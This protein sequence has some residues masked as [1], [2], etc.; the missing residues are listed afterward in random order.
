MM[1]NK[2]NI[3]AIAGVIG[4][5]LL[6]AALRFT[7]FKNF[8]NN[9]ESVSSIINGT[10]VG[11]INRDIKEPLTSNSSI[12][13]GGETGDKFKLIYEVST[14]E[15][16]AVI[17]VLNGGKVQEVNTDDSGKFEFEADTDRGCSVVVTYKEFIGK[18]KVKVYKNS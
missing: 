1:K 15:G 5:V 9:V 12:G 11:N 18:V 14:K 4:M 7:Q 16:S 8:T 2:K 6:I 3:A 13:V 10:Y 17:K